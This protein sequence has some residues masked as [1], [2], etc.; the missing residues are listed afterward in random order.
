VGQGYAIG[1][2][3]AMR[4]GEPATPREERDCVPGYAGAPPKGRPTFVRSLSRPPAEAEELRF[5]R[6]RLSDVRR[7][8]EDG[9]RL[10]GLEGTKRS[11][12]VLAASELAA[13]SILHGGGSGRVRVWCE[14]SSFFCEVIDRGHIDD[15]LVGRRRPNPYQ[16]NGRGLWIVAQVCDEVQVRTGDE[17][18]VVRARMQLH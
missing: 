5:D 1:E 4:R 18:T 2:R 17:G 3:G 15:P 6:T 9:A 10:A 14:A 12:I 8:V 7:Y 11:D 13:N 16:L